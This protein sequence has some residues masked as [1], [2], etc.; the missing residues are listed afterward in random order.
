MSLLKRL[1]KPNCEHKV[2][3]LNSVTGDP[4][5]RKYKCVKCGKVQTQNLLDEWERIKK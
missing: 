3:L 1:I 5:V 2:I 4:I